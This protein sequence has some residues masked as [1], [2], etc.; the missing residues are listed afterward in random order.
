MR[1]L[2]RRVIWSQV[3]ILATLVFLIL[4]GFSAVGR[5]THLYGLRQD[6]ARLRAEIAVLESEHQA[7]EQR[8]AEVQSDA[9]I[10]KV[11]REQLNLIKPGETAVVIVAAPAPAIV[12]ATPPPPPPPTPNWQRWWNLFFGD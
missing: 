8:K 3:L 6:E 1:L 4:I 9:Y 5:L 2:T 12:A 11:A 10:E 7:L